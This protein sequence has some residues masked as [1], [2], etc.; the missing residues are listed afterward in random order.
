[1]KHFI[2][3]L[4]LGSTLFFCSCRSD[5]S[6]HD[7]LSQ[8]ST[9]DAL[10]DGVYDGTVSCGELKQF[11][12]FGIGTFDGLEGE[13]IVLDGQVY[14]IKTD[15]IAYKVKDSATT[16]FA[17][18]TFFKTDKKIRFP[19]NLT[20][21]QFKKMAD[22]VIG[23]D[24]LFYA[25]KI[26]GRFKT[27]KTRSVPKQKKPYPQLKE[28]VKHQKIFNFKDVK[29]TVVGFRC[30][31]Y[32]KGINVTGYHLHFLTE[33][34]NGGGHILDFTTDNI[35]VEIDIKTDFFM[36]LPDIKAFKTSNLE[37]DRT[38]ELHKIEK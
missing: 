12:N 25:I 20:Y 9:I 2:I 29:G 19:S 21:L 7:I 37:K 35:T 18:V 32:V 24:N 17:A 22:R 27:M 38:E 31:P 3:T 16:P 6:E 11:G 5:F 28:V 36:T 4:L 33:D 15:G 13:M 1:M 34:K 14:Q 8:V 10:L 30:P 23:S 26:T